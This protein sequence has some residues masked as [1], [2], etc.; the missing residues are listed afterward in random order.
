MISTRIRG[1]Q[2]IADTIG[3]ICGSFCYLI[4]HL[5]KNFVVYYWIQGMEIETVMA[6]LGT[7]ALTTAVNSAIA[8]VVSV[9]LAA[10]LRPALTKAGIK[11]CGVS[12]ED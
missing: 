6:A 11:C 7:K 1:H 9:I 2:R 4:L 12:D 10:L 8:V 5:S 3:A